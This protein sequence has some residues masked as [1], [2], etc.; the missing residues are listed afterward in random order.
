MAGLALNGGLAGGDVNGDAEALVGLLGNGGG[1]AANGSAKAGWGEKAANGSAKAGCDVVVWGDASRPGG[2]LCAS[3]AHAPLASERN[4]ERAVPAAELLARRKLVVALCLSSAAV[5]IELTFGSIAGSL[6]IMTDAAHMASDAVAYGIALAASHLGARTATSAYNFGMGRAE[7]LGSLASVAIIW[8]VCLAL[9][10]EAVRRLRADDGAV[11]GK[12]MF[13]TALFAFGCNIILV[14]FFHDA[15]HARPGEDK[16]VCGLHELGFHDF[17]GIPGVGEVKGKGDAGDASSAT[18]AAGEAASAGESVGSL[19]RVEHALTNGATTNGGTGG[20]PT[21]KRPPRRKRKPPPSTGTSAKPKQQQQVQ[22]QAPQSGQTKASMNLRAAY[23]HIVGDLVHTGAVTFVGAVL[24]WKPAWHRLDP[25]CTFLFVA[26][27][28]G[29]TKNIACEIF[30]VLMQRAPRDVDVEALASRLASLP[31][32]VAV[33]RLRVWSVTSSS[34]H[35]S[36]H[37]E[38]GFGADHA[39]VLSAAS[40]ACRAAGL[41]VEDCALQLEEAK[42]GALVLAT[43][44]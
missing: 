41:D 33:R 15:M 28:L 14:L 25:I 35:L 44:V 12:V 42:A 2:G 4:L 3:R 22:Q 34:A 23:L 36:A 30:E 7:V 38:C 24:W 9:V 8:G 6:A 29:M 32:V 17:V 5:V 31:G 13:F 11:E 16:C 20:S 18:G 1:K 10:V 26:L 37:I 27:V 39:C 40:D 19:L 21:P 43:A